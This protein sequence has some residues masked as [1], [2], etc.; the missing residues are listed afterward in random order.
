LC[1]KINVYRPG[2]WASCSRNQVSDLFLSDVISD[3]SRSKGDRPHHCALVKSLMA[4]C[5]SIRLGHTV[6]NDKQRCSVERCAGRTVDDG[7]GTWTSSHN[8]SG[9]GVRD[10]TECCSHDRRAGFGVSKDKLDTTSIERSYEVKVWST[11]RH[12]KHSGAPVVGDGL[13]N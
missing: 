5:C 9:N 8:H 13:S 6:G 3:T 11:S 2:Q 1:V 10:H 4:S 12:P 7:C